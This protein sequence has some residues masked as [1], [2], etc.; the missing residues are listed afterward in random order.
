MKLKPLPAA[1]KLTPPAPK[2]SP[3]ENKPVPVKTPKA[4]QAETP[5]KRGQK[6]E[7][8]RDNV[9][10]TLL[11]QLS[12]RVKLAEGF[13]L[14]EDE[15]N[16]ISVEI[17]SQLFKCFGDTGQK[18]RN[19]YRSLMFN[20][21][22]T[23][24]ETLWRRICEKSVN[25]YQL[26]R[27]SPDDLASQELA[28]WRER[29]AKHTLDMIKK[30]EL[31]S[32]NYNRQMVFKTHKGEQVFEDDRPAEKVDNV[33]IIANLGADPTESINDNKDKKDSKDGDKKN[34]KHKHHRSRS[35][36]RSRSRERGKSHD[37]SKDHKSSTHK[38]HK[39]DRSR[40]KDRRK[41]S[42]SRDRSRHSERKRSRSRD[43]Y[44]RSTHKSSKNKKENHNTTEKLDNR[45]KEILDKLVDNR[46][47][48]P[49]EDRLWKHVPQDD[50]VPSTFFFLSS[51]YYYS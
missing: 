16:K 6:E 21:K 32:L 15:I 33:D 46:I 47:L 35:K 30:S 34:S 12:N 45:S 26:V 40:S 5:V 22:D 11:E 18:Y 41:R 44:R 2:P 13:N 3:K 38:D 9:K 14:A 1:P 4:R 37:K 29:E 49:L 24:N 43:R 42:R 36:D 8:I 23:K 27:L 28:L 10:K 50:I 51:I 31:E 7:N 25:P 20:I 19:K 48:P 17:E 39:R